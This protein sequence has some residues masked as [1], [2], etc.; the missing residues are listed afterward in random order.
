MYLRYIV[1]LSNIL[2]RSRI[3]KLK[4][5]KMYPKSQFVSLNA[6]KCYPICSMSI[7]ETYCISYNFLFSLHFLSYLL[8]EYAF[9]YNCTKQVKCLEPWFSATLLSSQ[10]PKESAYSQHV[11]VANNSKLVIIHQFRIDIHTKKSIIV[12]DNIVYLANH[13]LMGWCCL[14]INWYFNYIHSFIFVYQ[15]VYICR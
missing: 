6:V 11:I 10:S 7:S 1:S 15:L 8:L 9:V 13:N 3:A 4:Q 2:V 5:P 12:M 14:I